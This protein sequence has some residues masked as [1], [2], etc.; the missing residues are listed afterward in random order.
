VIYAQALASRLATQQQIDLGH[1][2]IAAI[3]RR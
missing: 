1:R 3:G 2:R